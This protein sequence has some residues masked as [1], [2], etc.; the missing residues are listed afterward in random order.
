MGLLPYF[1]IFI[2]LTLLI[3]IYFYRVKK[4]EPRN[5]SEDVKS[6]SNPL[7]LKTA[8]LFGSLFIFFAIVTNFVV[9]HYGSSGVN[10]LAFVV[11]VTDID[12]FILN[13]FQNKETITA[14]IIVIAV[15]NAI[16][17]NNALKMIYG[18]ALSDKS[19]RMQ[20]ITGFSILIAAGL[21]LAFWFPFH[22]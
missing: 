19:L 4:A 16:T 14:T 11:G 20:L 2:I 3:S 5:A 18:L 12:P 7:E 10:I 13:L 8:L 21:I 9:N 15:L 17:S 22:V 6:H 1:C